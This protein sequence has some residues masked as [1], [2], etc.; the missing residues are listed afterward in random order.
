MKKTIIALILIFGVII[1]GAVFSYEYISTDHSTNV[2]TSYNKVVIFTPHDDDETIGM[3][4]LI[5]KLKG[6]GKEVHVVVMCSGNGVANN[7]NNYYNAPVLSNATPA[8]SKKIIRKDAFVRVMNIDG[9]SY[10]IIGLD[11][12]GTSDENVFRVMNRMYYEGYGEFYTTTGDYNIDHQHCA[13][14]MKLMMEKHPQ[15]KYRQF[16]VYWHAADNGTVRFVPTPLVNNYTDYNVSE[17]LPIK[18]EAL[19]VY[20]NIELFPV[21]RYQTDIERM[22]YLN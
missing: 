4:G 5:Q 13:D 2:Q 12:G 7:L 18:K 19:Q 3:G 20:Y 8:D 15:L 17:Y 14:A 22:Y 9:V 6:E 1:I 16:P 10:E 11:D 21:S